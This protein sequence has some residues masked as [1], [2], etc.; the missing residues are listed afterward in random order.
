M[1]PSLNLEN[2]Q[3]DPFI[4]TKA[5]DTPL[6]RDMVHSVRNDTNLANQPSVNLVR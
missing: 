4:A 5:Y 2:E 6:Q 1:F 3:K